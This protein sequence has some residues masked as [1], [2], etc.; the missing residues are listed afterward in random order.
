MN[1]GE[2]RIRVTGSAR[3]RDQVLQFVSGG[4][5]RLK[6]AGFRVVVKEIPL[7][8]DSFIFEIRFSRA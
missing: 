6:T 1:L 2:S 5:E 7:P 4:L 3:D 8:Q